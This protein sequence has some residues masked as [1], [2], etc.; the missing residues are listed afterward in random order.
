[1][2]GTFDTLHDNGIASIINKID[3]CKNMIKYASLNKKIRNIVINEL[4][5]YYQRLKNNNILPNI[6]N[7]N[8]D[9]FTSLCHMIDRSEYF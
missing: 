3:S 4:P 1:M 6:R 8:L 7:I 2:D 9:Q 5:Y